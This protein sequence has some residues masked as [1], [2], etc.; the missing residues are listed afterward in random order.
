MKV[1]LIL[2]PVAVVLQLQEGVLDAEM[3]TTGALSDAINR[4]VEDSTLRNVVYYIAVYCLSDDMAEE[5]Q[6]KALI[7]NLIPLAGINA[8]LLK[9]I[10][11]NLTVLGAIVNPSVDRLALPNGEGVK[12]KLL[13]VFLGQHGFEALHFLL[14]QPLLVDKGLEIGHHSEVV[15]PDQAF[16]LVI[17]EQRLSLQVVNKHHE[18]TSG[19]DP[20]TFAP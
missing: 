13:Q 12:L 20:A 6:N 14:A 9:L 18:G 16:V 5:P 19:T 8:V 7:R 15:S 3:R 4:L 2:E 1:P 17:R 10:K 11:D